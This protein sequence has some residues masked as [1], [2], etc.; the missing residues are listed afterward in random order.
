MDALLYCILRGE[1][2]HLHLDE[3]YINARLLLQFWCTYLFCL[4]DPVTPVLCLLVIVGV[5]V[6][7]MQDHLDET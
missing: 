3:H 2:Y 6:K 1:P 4:T 7:V 5:E